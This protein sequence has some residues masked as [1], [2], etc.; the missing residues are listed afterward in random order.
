MEESVALRIIDAV[1]DANGVDAT[2][3]EYALHDYVDTDALRLL[4]THG[5]TW[6]LSFETPDHHVTVTSE[7]L[8]LVDGERRDVWT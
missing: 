1:A 5:G 8:I 7:G 4:A 6:S 2:E 3:L